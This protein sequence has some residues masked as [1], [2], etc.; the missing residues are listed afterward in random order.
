MDGG[1]VEVVQLLASAPHHRDQVGRLEQRE[2]LRHRLSR[3]GELLAQVRERQAALAVQAIEQLAPGAIGQ[4]FE[5]PVHVERY[6][7]PN[8]C[9]SSAIVSSWSRGRVKFLHA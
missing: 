4:R 1:R 3:H 5:D 8:G 2:V 7:Q 9:L 6:M